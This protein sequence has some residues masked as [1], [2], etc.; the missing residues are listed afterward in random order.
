[1]IELHMNT[2]QLIN[3][4]TLTSNVATWLANS[5]HPRILH[6]FDHVCNLINE[7]KEIISV[8]TSQIGDGPFS[9]VINY[10]VLFSELL[11]IE[12]LVSIS[13][14]QL[15]LGNMVIDAKN[16]KS[17]NPCPDWDNLHS[18]RDEILN[19]FH[20]TKIN[21]HRS[22]LST[23]LLSKLAASLVTSDIP[24]CRNVAKRIAGLGTGLTPSGDDFIM[25]AL[26]AAWII[27]PH[28][29]ASFLAREV[30][31]TAVPLTTS[32]SAAWIR[33]AGRGEVGLLWHELFNALITD[34][35]LELPIAKLLS[36]GETSGADALA[37]FFGVISA[38][39]ERTPVGII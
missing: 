29:V 39:K 12:S 36:V 33:S 2:M 27:H 34:G 21:S 18:K 35:D 32:L 4:P 5:H 14:N 3:A 10:D 26:Y 25:G 17:W 6:I 15:M 20:L 7:H 24:S 30:A 19:R 23:P 31:E 37:G 38:F 13:G 1:M 11:N 9:L 16:A 28:D 8:V 22:S